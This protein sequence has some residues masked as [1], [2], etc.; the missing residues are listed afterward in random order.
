MAIKRSSKSLGSPV[1][2]PVASA[3]L[4]HVDVIA[5]HQMLSGE[6]YMGWVCKNK[7]CGLVVAVSAAQTGSKPAAT[8]SDD[9]LAVIKCPHCGDENLYRWSARGEHKYTARSAGT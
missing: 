7:P 5:P 4:R 6:L 3:A 8:E 1:R 9:Q 2:K